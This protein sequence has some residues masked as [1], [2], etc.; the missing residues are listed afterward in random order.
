MTFEVACLGNPEDLECNFGVG[1]IQNRPDFIRRPDVELALFA[2]AIGIL[3]GME[4]AVVGGHFA[5]D[6]IQRR[7]DGAGKIGPTCD[8]VS[9]EIEAGE[10]GIVVEHLLEM[11]NKPDFVDRVSV[12]PTADLVVNSTF[13]HLL[14]GQTDHLSRLVIAQ[15]VV[16]PKQK[17]E[18]RTLGELRGSTE[19]AIDRIKLGAEAENGLLDRIDFN[20][21]RVAGSDGTMGKRLPDLLALR[22]DLVALR[23]PGVGDRIQHASKCWHAH[24]ILGWPIGSAK[25]WEASSR[26]KS[27]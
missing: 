8:A 4:R 1:R 23:L 16:C 18:D 22:Q 15:Q 2:F 25:K 14:K 5:Q 17:L 20:V 13:G 11:R 21:R 9:V 24:P 26:S 19:A 12:E 6:V 10:L 27:S 3:G 7:A